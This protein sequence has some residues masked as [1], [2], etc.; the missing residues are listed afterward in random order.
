MKFK[1]KSAI[2]GAASLAVVGGGLLAFAEAAYAAAPPPWEPDANA[3]APYGNIVFY[4]STGNV[5]TGG[6][7]LSHIADFVAATTGPDA[8]ANK[9]T[10]SFAAPNHANPTGLWTAGAAS[11]ST[12]FAPSDTAPAPITD[13]GFGNPVVTLGATDGN[14]AAFLGGVSL[15]STAGY[16][17]IIQVRLKDSG[18]GGVTSGSHYWESD[19]AYNSG[20]SAITVDGVSVAPGAWTQ[21]FPTVQTTTTTIGATPSSPQNSPS[22][23]TAGQDVTLN[24]TVAPAVAGTVQF[25]DGTTAVG[26]P[27]T[28]SGGTASAVATTPAFG[29]HSYTAV[30]TPTGGTEVQGSTSSPLSYVVNPPQTGT[31]TSLAGSSTAASSRQP[32]SRPRCLPRTARR[33][34][35]RSC[36][37]PPDHPRPRRRPC[38]APFRPRVRPR[39]RLRSTSA[40]SP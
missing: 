17:N 13:P 2:A 3:A 38:S 31:I 26:T 4:D 14:L 23:A 32:R 28:V 29:T 39:H 30:F 27:Q 15:D 33:S 16:A 10:L 6:A 36:S 22:G 34:P 5:L 11:A 9:A 35:A 20:S 19:I 8:G 40:R 18:P 21:L 12:T 25:F 1:L 37:R 7:N 24:A